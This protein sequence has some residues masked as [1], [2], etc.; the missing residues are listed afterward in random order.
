M[1]STVIL[2]D[3]NIVIDYLLER[4]P[5]LGATKEL[6]R[7]YTDGTNVDKISVRLKMLS[8]IIPFA[9]V[10]L[11]VIHNNTDELMEKRG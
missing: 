2:L 1:K 7:K 3:A 8:A 6:V 10:F 11:F 5:G 9:R 4:E